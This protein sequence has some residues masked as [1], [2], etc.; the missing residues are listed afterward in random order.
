VVKTAPKGAAL[1]QKGKKDRQMESGDLF[2][3]TTLL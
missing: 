2:F 1:I 3:E